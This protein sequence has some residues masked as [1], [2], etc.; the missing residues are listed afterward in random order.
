VPD[1]SD[2]LTSKRKAVEKQKE[3]LKPLDD[4]RNYEYPDGFGCVFVEFTSVTEARR[5]RRN[6][7]L[8]KYNGRLVEVEYHDEARYALND[9][10]RL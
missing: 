1:D 9:F 3:E 2:L 10:K 7:H 6:I 8:L 5:A 4:P